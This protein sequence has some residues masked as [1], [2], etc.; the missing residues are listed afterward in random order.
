MIRH[1]TSD[2]FSSD[3]K[4]LSENY[5]THV[6][7]YEHVSMDYLRTSMCLVVSVEDQPID[8]ISKRV[9]HSRAETTFPPD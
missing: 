3:K 5:T 9:S 4:Y 1:R 2:P 7:T 6:P 8:K